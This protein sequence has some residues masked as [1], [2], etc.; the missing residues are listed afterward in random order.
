MKRTFVVT[1]LLA[2]L[3]LPGCKLESL[4]RHSATF[5]AVETN[6]TAAIEY[7]FRDDSLDFVV[8]EIA[9]NG[10]PKRSEIYLTGDGWCRGKVILPSGKKQNILNSKTAFIYEVDRFYTF[11]LTI[12][13]SKLDAFISTTTNRYTYPNLQALFANK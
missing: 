5:M 13:K 10:T 8:I 12:S 7:G 4:T 11:P 1:L 3:F 9:T 2:S 6:L